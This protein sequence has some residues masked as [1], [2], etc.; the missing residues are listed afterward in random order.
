MTG[1]NH[2]NRRIVAGNI[3]KPWLI[4]GPFYEDLGAVGSMQMDR[5]GPSPS[6][7]QGCDSRGVSLILVCATAPP[8]GGAELDHRRLAASRGG[9]V[10]SEQPE[11]ALLQEHSMLAVL[12]ASVAVSQ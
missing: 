3:L 8:P 6:R 12:P 10:S 5:Q 11:S 9:R 2:F 7:S 1:E 4:L